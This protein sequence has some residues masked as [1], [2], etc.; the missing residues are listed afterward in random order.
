MSREVEIVVAADEEN[1][2]GRE[3]DI[4]W[5]LP[6]DLRFLKRIT[7]DT[8][9]ASRR[10]AVMMGRVTWETLPPKWQPLPR[11]LNA[12]VTRRAGY[13]V[14]EGVI[15][16]HGLEEA[17]SAID[18]HAELERVFCLGGGEIYR[19]MIAHP[20]CRRIYL[21]RV[22]GRHGCDAFFPEI[23]AGFSLVSESERHEENGTGYAFQTWE[24]AS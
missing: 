20:R 17:L 6:G 3:G 10:N 15:L 24:R 18:G 8:T 16:A 1:G 9:E 4:P 14:P 11:R 12:V 23:P 21:T 19:Q 13:T 7:S 22:E 2:I 5:H